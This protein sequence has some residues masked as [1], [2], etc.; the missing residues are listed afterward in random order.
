MGSKTVRTSLS[1]MW[2]LEPAR[3]DQRAPPDAKDRHCGARRPSRLWSARLAQCRHRAANR[4][5]SVGRTASRSEVVRPLNRGMMRALIATLS[6]RCGGCS[7]RSLPVR[8]AGLHGF[9]A[10][11]QL[12]SERI[13]LVPC[14]Q[15]LGSHRRLG[16]ALRRHWR[17][18]YR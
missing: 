8:G 5:R 6:A 9:A 18:P 17:G 2:I 14:L 13:R 1:P 15:L 12:G 16:G 11:L 3:P 10:V 7:L 4:S